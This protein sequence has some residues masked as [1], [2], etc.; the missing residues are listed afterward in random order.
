MTTD[1]TT[2]DVAGIIGCSAKT[3]LKLANR[4]RLRGYK[5]GRDW[6]FKQA[7]VDTFR[8]PVAPPIPSPTPTSRIQPRRGV[9][10]PGWNDFDR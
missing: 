1:L 7:A 9:G 4:G 8:Q 3:V 2:R 10:L 5:V 6:R